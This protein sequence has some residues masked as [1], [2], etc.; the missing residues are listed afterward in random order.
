VVAAAAVERVPA[1]QLQAQPRQLRLERLQ[2]RVALQ[3]REF[4]EQ[5]SVLTLVPQ[6]AG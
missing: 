6:A 3:P 2:S 1:L 5:L 4:R